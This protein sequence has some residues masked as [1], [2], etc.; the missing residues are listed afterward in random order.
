MIHILEDFPYEILK[1]NERSY[2]IMLLRDQYDNTFADIAKKYKIT[3]ARVVQIYNKI[4]LKQIQLYIHHI[5]VVL[6][7]DSI[8]Q[9]KK[10]YD[11]SYECY[12]ERLYVCAYME[13]KYKAI[14]DE[15]RNGEPGMP[16]QFLKSMPPFKLKLSKKTI[17]RVIEMR[18]AQKAS[19]VT[20]AK[21]LRITQAKAKRT[22]ETFYHKQVLELIKDLQERTESR[23]EKQAIWD[24]YFRGNRSSKKRYDMLMNNKRGKI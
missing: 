3:V 12:Q 10:I 20:I 11:D 7:H 8:S 13:K 21:E 5:A 19:F 24:Y 15:Y 6:G 22:Y 14:L 4:K 16:R 23:E 1:Q 17:A 9:V 2:E 18:E